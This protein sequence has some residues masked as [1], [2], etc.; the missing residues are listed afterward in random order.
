MR[1]VFNVVERLLREGEKLW[2]CAKWL[3]PAG[4][5]GVG[6]RV[7]R[8]AMRRRGEGKASE[9]EVREKRLVSG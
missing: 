5:E 8:F 4:V 3:E 7:R 6:R 1:C 2:G 9:T